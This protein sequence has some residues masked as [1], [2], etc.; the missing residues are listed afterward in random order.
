M[1]FDRSKKGS[2]S[3]FL[4]HNTPANHE[5]E[6]FKQRASVINT[7]PDEAYYVYSFEE[8]KMLYVHGW[9]KLVGIP[10]QEIGMVDIVNLTAPQFSDYVE[11]VN[12]KALMFLFT[13]SIKLKDYCFQIHI[14]LTHRNGTEIPISAKV[15]VYDTFD[16]GR[17]KS[18]SG[19]FRLNDSLRFGKVMRLTSYGPE[20]TDFEDALDPKLFKHL[21]ITEKEAEA[22]KLA[23]NGLTDKEIADKIG[24]SIHSVDKRF[25]SIRKRFNCRSRT[26]LLSFAF[27][28]YLL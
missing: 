10:D 26:E 18:I 15:A 5:S 16:D 12:D 11:E 8:K 1:N 23:A 17:L 25:R 6:F 19:I 7:F 28:N 9:G 24:I 20:K 4:I 14:K 21:I 22:L 13:H 3:R 27:E 2:Y